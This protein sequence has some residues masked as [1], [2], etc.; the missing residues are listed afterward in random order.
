MRETIIQTLKGPKVR[1]AIRRRK[2]LYESETTR[3]FVTQFQTERFN[4]VWSKALHESPFYRYWA[5]RHSL[6]QRIADIRELSNFPILTKRDLMEHASSLTSSRSKT[7]YVSGGSTGEPTKFPKGIDEATM[8]YADHVVTHSWLGLRPGDRYVHLWGHAHLFGQG[9]RALIRKS[10][11]KSKDWLVGGYRLSA[12]N[13]ATTDIYK[14]IEAIQRV[15]PRYLV[16]YASALVNLATEIENTKG[17]LKVP[18]LEWL[19]ST[20]ESI[21]PED[22]E[23]LRKVFGIPVAIEY[24]ANETGVI[25]HSRPGIGNRLQMLWASLAGNVDQTGSLR[26][27]TLDNRS[28]PLINYEIGDR[29]GDPDDKENVLSIGSVLGRTSEQVSLRLSDGTLGRISMVG[30][31]GALKNIDEVKTV[32]AAQVAEDIIEIYL[33]GVPLSD[34]SSL[35][36]LFL[37]DLRLTGLH[38]DPSAVTIKALEEPIR[39]LAGKTNLIVPRVGH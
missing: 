10:V 8:R 39:S 31:V 5:D 6:P 3:D 20:A 37:K 36:L 2:M 16:G 25:A 23:R 33:T 26:L 7:F 15:R 4:V 24:G 1:K 11:R 30:I 9:R 14:W 28:F 22:I 32:Q 21:L 34:A 17:T 27:S 19:I 18:S 12:Y 29:V 38:V 35:K 13:Q